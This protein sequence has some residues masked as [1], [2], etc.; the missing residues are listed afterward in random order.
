MERLG[1]RYRARDTRLDRTVAIKVLPS[2]TAQEQQFRERFEREARAASALNHP[3]ILSV[4]AVGREAAPNP[5][6][7]NNLPAAVCSA[8]AS[9]SGCPSGLSRVEGRF[10]Q[11]DCRRCRC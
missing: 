1:C 3:N 6:I 10:T 9:A 2:H 4:F 11:T 7:R 5:D 8:L